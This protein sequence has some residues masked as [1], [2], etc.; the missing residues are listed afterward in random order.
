MKRTFTWIIMEEKTLLIMIIIWENEMLELECI[1][2]AIY[3]I[4]L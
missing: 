1:F 3:S 2:V 4:S